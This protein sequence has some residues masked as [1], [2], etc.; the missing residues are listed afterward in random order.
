MHLAYFNLLPS[1]TLATPFFVE[2]TAIILP[3]NRFIAGTA[4]PLNKYHSEHCKVI[5]ADLF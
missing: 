1:E 3:S 4:H 2:R 5:C